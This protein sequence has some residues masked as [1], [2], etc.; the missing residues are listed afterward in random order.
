M[1]SRQFLN[2]NFCFTVFMVGWIFMCTIFTIDTAYS[3]NL[4]DE[5][6]Q[7]LALLQARQMVLQKKIDDLQLHKQ[8]VLYNLRAKVSCYNVGDVAQNDGSPCV[9]SSGDDLCKLVAAG[10]GVCATR[11]HPLHTK[12]EFE[13][14][15][16]CEVLDRTSVKYATRI[17]VAF[18]LGAKTWGLKSLK[19]RIV[20]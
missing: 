13:D 2:F 4:R 11:L 3:T 15:T 10:K 17:D 20:N 19:Y 5:L 16:T 6:K 1:K 9:G 7:E 8:D 12:L 18:P 14:G